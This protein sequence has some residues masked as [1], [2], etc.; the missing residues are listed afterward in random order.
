LARG[1]TIRTFRLAAA[2]AAAHWL[3]A[4]IPAASAADAP[5]ITIL[6]ITADFVVAADGSYVETLHSEVR[7]NNDAAAMQDGQKS[8]GYV[9][10]MQKMEVL[11]AYTL[12]KDG[13][14]FP[15]DASAI[16][17]QL[18]PGMP[19]LPMFTDIRQKT[20]IFPQFAAGDT[21]VLTL[22]ITNQAYFPGK[23]WLQ[24][25][26]PRTIAVEEA[27]DTITVPKSLPLH[28]ESDDV[29][30]THKEVGGNIVYSWNYTNPVPASYEPR[31]ISP[32]EGNPRFYVSSL[33]DYG[34]VGQL[35]ADA[36]APKM[37][38]T[39]AVRALAMKITEGTTDRREQTRKIYE[40]VSG[41][42]RYV[43]EEL[44]K[45]SLVP[46]DADTI[47]SNGYGDCKDHVVLLAALLKARGIDSK[48]ILIN[49]GNEYE[50]PKVAT[51]THLNHV[52]T[53]VP[54]F[55][56]YMDSTAAIS[57]LGTLPSEEYGKPIVVA[58]VDDPHLATM[59]LLPS[60]LMNTFTKTAE[61]IDKDGVL[62][63]TTTT[64][65]S[66]PTSVLLRFVGLGVQKL[67]PEDAAAH[68]LTALGYKDATGRLD[69]PPPLQLA[70][71]YTVTGTFRS[72]DWKEEAAGSRSFYLPGGMRLLGIPGDGLMGPLAPGKLKDTEPVSCFSGH[73][74]EDISLAPP[75]GMHFSET[76]KDVSIRTANIAFTT[77]W[78]LS[79][80]TLAVKRDFL[81]TID[82]PFCSAEIRKAN[83]DALKQ[84]SDS[85]NQTLYLTSEVKGAAAQSASRQDGVEAS[86]TGLSQQEID[87]FNAAN[88]AGKKADYKTQIKL[89]TSL[90]PVQKGNEKFF[91]AVYAQ[92]AY[93]H[94]I[95]TQ[96]AAALSDTSM[97]LDL[98]PNQMDALSLRIN[99]YMRKSDNAHALTDLNRLI[100]M[101]PW[102][103]YYDMRGT[104]LIRLGQYDRA[105]SDYN[106]LLKK[107]PS[108]LMYLQLRGT[109]Y[110]KTGRFDEAVV[111]LRRAAAQDST[112][113]S[114][115]TM[116]CEAL[117]RSSKPGD[118]IPKCTLLLEYAPYLADAMNWRGYAYYRLGNF[119]RAE[120]D[121][122]GAVAIYPNE[123]SYLFERGVAKTKTGD[124]AG[125]EKDIAAATR[126]S[127]AVAKKMAALKITP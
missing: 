1:L 13:H 86:G 90:L 67:G 14:K 48:A 31:A 6:H 76:P 9:A 34:E 82:Q 108:N 10:S 89:L 4:G 74:A 80:D 72:T 114:L 26:F 18:P 51:F 107:S 112:D 101:T 44:G 61:A 15:V 116:L 49:A 39:S 62:T 47:L 3:C 16:Y 127:A 23:F 42:I 126:M 2:A 28:I 93:A 37:A 60:G 53:W 110:L 96:Y 92:R 59:P 24:D 119:A 29:D 79:G 123:A 120:H 84:I 125:G 102:D 113:A 8:F 69:A 100:A 5:A 81:A 115:H 46:H 73:E 105:I 45:G 91:S 106:V 68:I 63:G 22:K 58:S 52:I 64:E 65:T 87:T 98:N 124:R 111:D 75:P 103:E 32:I 41:H 94:E 97:A 30:Y 104:V 17:D 109:A 78:S 66:G 21:E 27:R 7:A 55:D 85:Y 11:E 95:L 99:L 33:K 88:A 12:K 20:I 77:H 83:A 54:E 71:S 19:S 122:D 57:P 50:L 43:A 117:A 25:V 56:L 35:F 40:W 121:F 70:P 38:V 118:A 36:A